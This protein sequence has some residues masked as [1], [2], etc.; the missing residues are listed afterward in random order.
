[1]KA[2]SETVIDQRKLAKLAF[3]PH[4]TVVQVGTAV[5]FQN[6]DSTQHH[7]VWP[8]LSGNK[9]LG[10]NLGTWIKGEKRS[11]KFD[12]PGVVPLLCNVYPEMASYVVVSP[13]PY[14][15]QT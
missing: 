9:K 7:V 10:H 4:I 12:Q 14:Y 3:D 11:F 5:D 8:S 13:T 2:P 1:M 15:A 6:D